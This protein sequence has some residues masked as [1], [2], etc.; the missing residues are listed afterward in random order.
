MAE[1]ANKSPR[2]RAVAAPWLGRLRHRPVD[3]RPAAA[4]PT[5]RRVATLA[6]GGALALAA[7][8]G[9]V[10]LAILYLPLP[11][12]QVIPRVKAAIEQRL[13][14]DYAVEIA[15]AEL[16]RGSDGVELRLVDLAIAKIEAGRAGP[17]IA[18]VPRAELRLD[19]LGLLKGE[20][21]VRSV[22]VTA[23]KL[24]MRFDTT[25]DAASKN[26]DLPDRILAAIGD[27]DRLLGADGAAGALEN[28]EVTDATLLVAPRARAPLSLEGVDLRLSR[29]TGGS[30]ALT[31]SSARSTDRWTAAITV[32]AAAGDKSRLVDLGVENVDLAP[33]SAPLAEK[34]GAPPVAGRVSGHINARIG[35]D[36]RLLA[37]DGRLEARALQIFMPGSAAD[38]GETRKEIALDRV[39][40]ALRWDAPARTVRV[41][42][43]QIRGRGG[44]VTFTGAFV[45]PP[46]PGRPW[47]AMLAGRDVLL[48]GETPSDP[49]LRLDRIDVEATFDPAAGVLDITKAQAV[50]PTASAALTGLIRF[51]GDSPAIRVGLVGSPMPASAVKRL[52]PF[53]LATGVR[54]WVVENVGSGRVDGV[55]LTIDVQS[56]ALAKLKPK[57]PFPEGSV[58][59]EVLFTDGTLR[60]KPG[61]P[62]LEGASGRIEA[63]SRRVDVAVSKA[64]IPGSPEEGSLTV[65]DLR[66]TVPDLNHRYPPATLTMNID[67]A[68]RK[69]LELVASGAFGKNPLPAQI[70]LDKVAGRI[71]TGVSVGLELDHLANEGPPPDVRMTA[72]MR[73]VKIADLYAGH[74]FEKG[75]FQLKIDDGPPKLT[76]KGSVAGAA[77]SVALMEEPSGEGA[78]PKRK[79]AVTLTTAASDLTRLGFDVPGSLKGSVPLS[80]EIYLDDPAAPMTVKADLAKVGIDGLAPGFVKPVG[81]PGRLGFIV[82]RSPER[83]LI[84]DFVLES[85]DRS[86][87]GSISFGPKGDLVSASMPIYRPGPG[88]DARIELDRVKGG[89]TKVAVQG[90]ALDLRPL[91]QLYRKK[92]AAS[93]ARDGPAEGGDAA[94]NLDVSAKLGTAI[95]YGGQ[96]L[97]GLDL[98]LVVRDGKVT[99]ADGTGRVGSGAVRLAIGD[100]GRLM[101]SGQDAGAALRF[102]DLY[103]RID[104]G[105]FDLSA[106]LAG[107][108]GELRIRDFSV[109]DENALTRVRQTT[110]TDRGEPTRPGATKFDRL[111][112][113]FKQSSGQIDVEEA[114][115][116]GPQLGATLEGQ[117]NYAADSVD[118][119][120]TFVPVYALNNLFSRV[121]VIGP[122][123][124]GGEHG[125]LLGVTFRVRGPTAAPTLT[126]NPMS[127]VAPGFLRKLFEFRQ[128]QPASTSGST[129]ASTQQ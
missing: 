57:E 14:P 74:S 7:T 19:G 53:F 5:A 128:N 88:D 42:S 112:V 67:G 129:P 39:Q 106:S 90:A 96:A 4:P 80:A 93:G 121:P 50:G 92:P 89:V 65:S 8:L 35:E 108:P 115:V 81:R 94:K 48:A 109:R 122:L 105:S 51:E 64:V 49:P 2:S 15:D 25:V 54:N 11:A 116:Y 56:G 66:F 45:A 30:I 59:L 27:L 36:G 125:G 126:V 104:R 6:L 101:V 26:S 123:L 40:F 97:A 76:G 87:R 69:A 61:L 12:S 77:A 38:T 46:E 52:W 110:G 114:V 20:V 47:A 1:Q 86:V 32:S 91:M 41:E 55:S 127:A 34:A 102:V 43:S 13:G 99:D 113:L 75:A 124:G 37:G 23:P 111:R 119:V 79:L 60:G 63:T 68:L 82:E 24:D 3:G 84:R 71:E 72:D 103:G 21:R 70:A 117:V 118:L 28:V 100:G 83:T 95:G 44:Q 73:D 107:G 62:W 16:H 120:G 33:Y 29:G 31:A 10:W 17:P 22:H 85:G 58:S 98:K 18:S 9:A 78:P